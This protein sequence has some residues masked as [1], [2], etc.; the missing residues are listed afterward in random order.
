MERVVNVV[1]NNNVTTKPLRVNDNRTQNGGGRFHNTRKCKRKIFVVRL[2][3]MRF[4]NKKHTL[5]DVVASTFKF[6]SR[7]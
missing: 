5:R 1:R 6:Y 3:M 2:E 7:W 4:F